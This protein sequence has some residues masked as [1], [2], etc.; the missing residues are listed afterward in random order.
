MEARPWQLLLDPPGSAAWNM[1]VDEALLECAAGGRPTLRLYTWDRPS[2]S[3]GYRQAP[4]AWL[5]RCEQLQIPVVRRISG[6][7]AVLH[8]GDLTYATVAPATAHELPVDLHGSY[9]WIRGVLLEGLRA[10]G[11]AVRPSR[12]E[13]GAE[14]LGICFAGSTGLEIELEQTK[15]VGSAQRRT[16]WGF[17]QHGSIRLGG[18]AALCEALWG[19]A[20]PW[21]P[22][23]RTPEP[24][25]LCKSICDA[26][27]AALGRPLASATLAEPALGVAQW[28]LAA[29]TH[30]SLAVPP[31]SL[32]RIP[33]FADTSA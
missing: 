11:L 3:L 33:T 18:D 19:E 12:A 31:L 20:P 17:L 14:R 26:F 10:A 28:R 25:T 24:E 2:L 6:G 27:S 9:A 8:A 5:E 16:R 22:D 4:P 7:G 29:R 23:L 1:S 15:L 21:P 13:P 30:D 32:R